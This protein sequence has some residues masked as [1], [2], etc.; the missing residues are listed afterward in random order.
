MA[1]T[2]KCRKCGAE[3]KFIK[4]TSGKWLPV[5]AKP[6]Y[7]SLIGKKDRVV[8]TDGRVISCTIVDTATDCVGYM[9]HWATCEF[10]NEFRR[11]NNGNYRN[12]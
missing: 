3:I 12:S 6:V 1:Q 11:K 2:T 5:D 10:A 4:T 9:P 7:Y 8:T